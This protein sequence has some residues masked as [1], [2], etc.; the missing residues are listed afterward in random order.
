VETVIRLVSLSPSIVDPSHLPQNLKI[1]LCHGYHSRGK[2]EEEEKKQQQQEEEEVM[3][4]E[5]EEEKILRN[6]MGKTPKLF[7]FCFAWRGDF[8]RFLF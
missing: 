6:L 2:R 7:F 8:L 1:L 4:E 5:E 3:E